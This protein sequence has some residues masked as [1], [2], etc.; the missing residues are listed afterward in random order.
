MPITRISFANLVDLIAHVF[1]AHGMTSSNAA[2]VA[3]VVA[4]AERDGTLSHGLLRVPGYVSTLKS[5]W[6]DGRA[7]P[8]VVG[9]QP[10]MVVVDACNGF[11]QVALV[12]GRNELISK[13]RICGVAALAI[14][15]SHHF[16]SVY[17]DV[18]PLAEQGL[19]ALA[20]L[21]S[22]SRLVPSGGTSKLFGSNPMA[23]A[24]PRADGPALVFDQASSIMAQGEVLLAAQHERTLP[25]G[26][27][28][29]SAGRATTDPKAI[30]EGGAL[31][32]FGGH[33][34]SSI[35]LMVELLAAAVTG[36]EFGFE[37]AS[38]AFPGAQSSRA[39]QL[40]IAID[41]DKGAGARFRHRVEELLIRICG[42]G[43][44]RLP[45]ERRL[46]AREEANR[47]GVPVEQDAL[48]R[49][50]ALLPAA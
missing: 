33:K 49:V 40:I 18:E 14:R 8:R 7:V 13:S 32:P 48:D 41:P 4:G 24:C 17:P 19:V 15:N 31:L 45:G 47:L 10:G 50:R 38:G 36:G 27:G 16:A 26:V 46:K 12:A 9:S 2:I 44:A 22:R 35:A 1:A 28:V 39:G 11:A 29:D 37:D 34:G 3:Q 43:S 42:N 30:L 21:N 23:F 20:F 6:V 25:E 5:G